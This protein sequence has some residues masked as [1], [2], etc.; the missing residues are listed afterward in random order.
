MPRSLLLALLALGCASRLTA[1]DKPVPTTEAAAKMTAPEGFRVT[2]FA[3]EPD[4]VQP[5]AFTF[6]TSGRMWVVECLSYPIW[7]KDGT[8]HDR[9]VILEDT[10][11]DGRFDKKSVFLDTGS[12]LSGIELGFGGVWL[13]S[14]PNLLFIPVKDD[15][16]S[17]QPVVWL[18]GWNVK[19]TK[20]NVFNSLG[21]GPDGWLY[22]CNGIQAKAWVGKPGTP[23]KDRTYLDGGVWRYHPTRKVFEA[24]AH[25][26]T[27]PWGLDWDD[28][29]EMFIT[30]CV[31]DH[32]WH[33]VP[34]RH[35]PRMYGQAANP[36]TYDL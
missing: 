4:I 17:G 31:I 30:N 24:V 10:D 28:Y 15:K 34:G 25:G 35:Y 6:D 8:G 20:H 36:S 7:S 14:S 33:V 26:T 22:G 13:C 29:G 23:Q 21:W 5:I 3:G 27:N 11:G 9:V 18:D 19:D 32:L 2:L 12:N 1:A 16:P